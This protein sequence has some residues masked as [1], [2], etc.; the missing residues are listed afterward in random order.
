MEFLWNDLRH[1]ARSLLLRPGFTAIAVTVLALGIGINATIFSALHAVVLRPLPYASPD[2]LAMVWQEYVNRDFG[3]V[4]LPYENFTDL[5]EASRSFE[6]LGAFSF[7]EFTIQRDETVERLTGA[8]LS[9][10]ML[11]GL[12][13]APFRGRHFLPDEEER[14]AA[15]VAVISHRLWQT[16]FASAPDL[17]GGTV[18]LDDQSY[19]VVGIMP[20]GFQFPP[21]FTSTLDGVTRS[22]ASAE[23]W[24]PL[25]ARDF[26]A[27]R[28]QRIFLTLGRLGE[29]VAL[30]DAQREADAIAMRLAEAYPGP[31]TDLGFRIVSLHEQVVGGVRSALLILFGAVT[32]VT[33]IAC[34]NVASLLLTRAAGRSQ[35]MAIRAALG[36][37][38][39]HLVR[40]LLAESFWLSVLGGLGGLVLARGAVGV[41]VAFGPADIPRLQE[42]GI[43]GQVLA[44]TLGVSLLTGLLFG[45]APAWQIS[46]P[47]LYQGLRGSATGASAGSGG[48]RTRRV[49]AAGQLASSVVLLA[50]AGLVLKSLAQ[51]LGVNPGF[52]SERLLTMHVFVPPAVVGPESARALLHQQLMERLVLVPGV[53]A[54]GTVGIPPLSARGENAVDVEVEG[55]DL[56]AYDERPQVS[57]RPVSVGYM[58]A[59]DIPLRQGRSFTAQDDGAAPDVAIV[60]ETMAAL[61]WPDE[62]AIG[63]RVLPANRDGWVEVVGIAGDVRHFGLD[64]PVR[65]EM[66][67]PY[68]Q[69][70]GRSFTVVLRT[71]GEPLALAP[72]ARRAVAE[73]HPDLP[74]SQ[75]EAM[76]DAVAVS[77][78]WPRL[79][80]TLLGLFAA[81]ALALAMVG[82]YGMV[83]H[84]VFHRTREMG[85]RLALGAGRGE[86]LRLIL[87]QEMMPVAIGIGV[88]VLAAL[89]LTRLLESLLFGVSPNDPAT[90][91]LVLLVLALVAALA[92][93]VPVAR[94]M[95]VDP[96]VALRAE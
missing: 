16:R 93:V 70:P 92:C 52:D 7:Q 77:V 29:G 76:D 36:A 95:R 14:G 19:T 9:P 71:T 78:A 94:A 41:L 84:A 31:N 6:T 22:V 53:T 65:P 80:A 42:V 30:E 37:G 96:T 64:A 91:G 75:V 8:R 18:T 34:A 24:V 69:E 61:L 62:S 79:T 51:L 57:L 4:N 56:S 46:S 66:H 45:L 13:V 3:L 89:F 10:G 33:L 81:V 20:A 35:E 11:A 63:R 49:L 32:L 85:V 87:R 26:P 12:G 15:P 38:R 59:M 60:N 86:I 21:S 67:V 82:V 83:S 47:R 68:A 58:D 72:T 23:L 90:M 54:V 74:V 40:Q 5:A 27:N 48:I 44:F 1:G 17:P 2:R 50:A 43:H 55:R 28:E 73:V 39:G 25:A 88:G